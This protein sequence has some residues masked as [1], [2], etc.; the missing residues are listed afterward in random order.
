MELTILVYGDWKK[1]ILLLLG[2]RFCGLTQ[3]ELGQRVGD[4]NGAAVSAGIRRLE[5]EIEYGGV[6]PVLKLYRRQIMTA[7]KLRYLSI[8]LVILLLGCKTL[9]ESDGNLS[10]NKEITYKDSLLI[11]IKDFPEYLELSNYSIM[12]FKMS[13]DFLKNTADKE[14]YIYD[15]NWIIVFEEN[16]ETAVVGTA[17]FFVYVDRKTGQI[18]KK[19]Y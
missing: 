12:Q 3:I 9:D 13:E 2:H 14:K 7:F 6:P 15:D 16:S 1:W 5:K 19:S 18:T 10:Q 11:A 17:V 4:V 8:N